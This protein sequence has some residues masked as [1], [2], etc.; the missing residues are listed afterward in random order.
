M[1]ETATPPSQQMSDRR[2]TYWRRTRHF[3]LGS[4]AV[5]SATVLAILFA[6]SGIVQI[7][8]TILG[9]SVSQFLGVFGFVVLVLAVVVVHHA[10]QDRREAL[11]GAADDI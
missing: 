6:G 3:A 9:F 8:I 4:L 1:T 7:P 11:Y 5:L 2:A 10:R